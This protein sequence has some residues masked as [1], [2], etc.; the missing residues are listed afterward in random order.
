LQEPLRMVASYVQLL[1]RRYKDKLD[2]DAN[3]FIG[4]AVDGATRMQALINAL[5]TYSR[6]GTQ[7]KKFEWTDCEA[8]LDDTLAGLRAAVEESGAVITRD[9][10]PTVMGDATQLG[11]LFQNLIGNGIKFRGA[12][13]P[14]I[15]ISSQRNAKAWVFS[16]R[17]RG[18]GF[19]SRYA[20]RIFV[21]FQRLHAQGAYPGTGIGLAVC[22]KIVERHGG[23]IWVESRPGEGATFYFSIPTNGH[24]E[25]NNEYAFGEHERI[26]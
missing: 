25:E 18:I 23:E 2:P 19:D 4:F 1:A 3:E 13:P 5:L 12:E 11:Q 6:L 7:T 26:G 20:E 24:G 14:R 10:L 9:P 22:K 15:H 16:V 21:M 8:V 17:D